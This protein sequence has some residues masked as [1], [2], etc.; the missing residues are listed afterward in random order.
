MRIVFI[1]NNLPSQYRHLIIRLASP[2]SGH[3]VVCI[4]RNADF[5]PP[6]VTTILCQPEGEADFHSHQYLQD[7]DRLIRESHAACRALIQLKQKGFVPD[8][9]CSHL[10]LGPSLYVK[11]IFPDVPLLSYCEWYISTQGGEWDFDPNLHVG[12][13]SR[14]KLRTG[15][16]PLLLDLV[17]CDA[18]VCPTRWQLSRFPELFH[19]KISVIHDGVDTCFFC[20]AS[21]LDGLHLPGLSLLPGTELV[22]YV[23]RGM[24]SVRG[25]PQFME[26]VALLL[27]QRPQCHI[28]VVGDE[29]IAYGPKPPAGDSYKQ[30]MLSRLVLDHSRLHFTGTLPYDQYLQVLQASSVHVYLTTPFV[31]S[32]SFMEAMAAGC[33][34]VA[35]NTEPVREVIRNGENGLLVDFFDTAALANRIGEALD[36]GVEMGC[37]RRAARQTIIEQYDLRDMLPRQIG[38]MESLC[39]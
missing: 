19:G 35:S 25:F 33:L 39:R 6:G 37:L 32:W 13:D 31:L 18:G 36:A 21:T 26:T 4:T 2:G 7:F 28:V 23:S 16:A 17:A 5:Y 30:W 9:I 27:K 11:D 1:H 14:M 22:T 15:N 8:I 20:P 3:Q 24:D 38:L 12:M 34:M 29:T 10:G